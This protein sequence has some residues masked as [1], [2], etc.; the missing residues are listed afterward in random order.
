VT[1]ALTRNGK[2]GSD[3][4]NEKIGFDA[5]DCMTLNT[6]VLYWVCKRCGH[7]NIRVMKPNEIKSCSNCGRF[8]MLKRRDT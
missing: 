6:G 2:G 7:K 8:V 3:M 5:V 1:D 4:V